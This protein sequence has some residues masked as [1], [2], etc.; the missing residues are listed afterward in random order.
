MFYSMTFEIQSQNYQLM[1]H[2]IQFL[3]YEKE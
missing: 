1:H 2:D 3:I